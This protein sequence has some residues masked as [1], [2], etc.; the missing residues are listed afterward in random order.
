[1]ANAAKKGYGLY[2]PRR[3]LHQRILRE[4]RRG[5]R[6]WLTLGATLF[7]LSRVRRAVSRQEE[8]ASIDVLTPGQRMIVTTTP[9]PSRRQRRRAKQAARAG[10]A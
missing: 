7:V 6:V 9:R 2:S 1:M 5:S 8:L 3:L 10:S 4:S